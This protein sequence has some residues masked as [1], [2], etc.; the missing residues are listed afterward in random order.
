MAM[1]NEGAGAGA[2]AAA[3]A[4]CKRVKGKV[5]AVLSGGMWGQ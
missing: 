2:A 5:R 1:E 4:R 3:R